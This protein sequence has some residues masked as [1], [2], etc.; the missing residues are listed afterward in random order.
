V[1]TSYFNFELVPT[2]LQCTGKN[3]PTVGTLVGLNK[4]EVIIQVKGTSGTPL[5]VHFPRLNFVIRVHN[6]KL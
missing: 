6:A 2:F 4:E 3:H 1:N 5:H